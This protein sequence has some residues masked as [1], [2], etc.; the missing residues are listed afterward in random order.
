MTDTTTEPV[1]IR[2]NDWE[3]VAA[4]SP[5]AKGTTSSA[6]E[7]EQLDAKLEAAL[8]KFDM[9]LHPVAAETPQLS[10]EEYLA[11]RGR[12]KA[13]G[14]MN[15]VIITADRQLVDG[16]HRL[17]CC[18]DL[19]LDPTVRY[20]TDD[21]VRN[22]AFDSEMRRHQSK[23]QMAAFT[24]LFWEDKVR[25]L[26]EAGEAKQRHQEPVSVT[27][28]SPGA[29]VAQ[30]AGVGMTAAN[31]AVALLNAGRVDLLLDVRNGVISSMEKA[32]QQ[33]LDEQKGAE[34]R[35]HRVAELLGALSK[36]GS[37][38]D[39]LGSEAETLESLRYAV[40]G[41]SDLDD[42]IATAKK[43]HQT[44][45]GVANEIGKNLVPA[46][47]EGSVR[48]E[49]AAWMQAHAD[50]APADWSAAYREAFGEDA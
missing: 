25:E 48:A 8:S 5:I 35:D 29:F 34:N 13:N 21:E 38:I 41:S 40:E 14:Q 15:S 36:L 20:V 18:Y 6:T 1:T 3:A 31:M 28:M 2:Q 27:E 10:M 23:S 42:L 19:G 26:T 43:L 9:T 17:M 45:A 49:R 30:T 47:Y 37:A 11:L 32:Y 4:A 44:Y 22:V 12:I 50:L 16:R 46:G 33:H 39:R 7:A 24:V